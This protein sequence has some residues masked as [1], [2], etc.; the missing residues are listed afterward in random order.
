MRI[1]LSQ[2]GYKFGQKRAKSYSFSLKTLEYYRSQ[3]FFKE[4]GQRPNRRLDHHG[5]LE[6][7]E[8]IL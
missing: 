5:T 8:D 2:N 1:S 7:G 4:H 3:V 6:G